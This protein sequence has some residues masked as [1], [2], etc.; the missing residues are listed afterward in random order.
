VTSP[1]P[2]EPFLLD[3]GDDAERVPLSL[4]VLDGDPGR[5]RPPVVL[6]HGF[7]ELAWS[8][9]HQLP[10]VADAGFTAVAPD[11]RGYGGS[12]APEDVSAYRMDRLCGDLIGVLD[13]LEAEG[14]VFVGHDWGGFVAW[15]MPVLHPDRCAGVVGVCT[16]YLP[17]PTTELLRALFGEDERMYMLWFQQPGTAEAVLDPR[18]RTL[19]TK[20]LRGGVGPEDLERAREQADPPID[21]NP[22]LHLDTLVPVG[23]RIVD[24][25]E[26]EHYVRV[27]ERTGFGGG[28]NW[29]RNIDANAAAFPE[30]GTVPLDLPALMLSAEWDPA[31]RPELAAGMPSLCSDLE[32]HVIERAGHWVQQEDPATLNRLLVDWLRR[33]FG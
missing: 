15:A 20:L 16:P 29:Y 13:H 8:W 33:R 4:R 5:E 12:G 28:I 30:L 19:F 11:M 26:L 9:R 1:N 14:A 18:A 2:P 27:F 7:P 31:L 25:D 21:A 10:A 32:M 24:D 22:F 6:C 3:P 17:F 23:E